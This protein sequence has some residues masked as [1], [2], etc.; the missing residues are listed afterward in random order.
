MGRFCLT[1]DVVM[2]GSWILTTFLIFAPLVCGFDKSLRRSLELRKLGFV[3]RYPGAQNL[4]RRGG[5]LNFGDRG[6]VPEECHGKHDTTMYIQLNNI[7]ED[8]Y[9]LYK[10]PEVHTFCRADCFSTS[11]F[12]NCCQ[13]LLLKEDRFLKMV[14]LYWALGVGLSSK[15]QHIGLPFTGLGL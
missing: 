1:R 2:D 14:N 10:D 15:C 13:A 6:G 7:C 11:F 9:N 12:Q 4:L 8:C 5:D 3:A